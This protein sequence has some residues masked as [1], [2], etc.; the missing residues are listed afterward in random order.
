MLDTLFKITIAVSLVSLMTSF[1]IE[2]ISKVLLR[3]GDPSVRPRLNSLGHTLER[4]SSNLLELWMLASLVWWP[5]LI[6]W[7]F[8]FGARA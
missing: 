5:I 7:N 8:F 4:A 3:Y 2:A 1:M 6:T